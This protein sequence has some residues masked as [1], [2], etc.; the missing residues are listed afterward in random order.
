MSEMFLKRIRDAAQDHQARTGDA[1]P[2]PEARLAAQQAHYDAFRR[3]VVDTVEPAL[4]KVKTE[5]VKQGYD[6]R[7]VFTLRH[8]HW[9]AIN[10]N[11]VKFMFWKAKNDAALSIPSEIRIFR[12]PDVEEIEVL[13]SIRRP[14]QSAREESVATLKIEDLNEGKIMDIASQAIVDWL[15]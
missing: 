6:S 4:M 9:P 10:S 5:L 15:S 11:S 2:S 8:N 14:R 7:V 12:D 1:K 13:K 3:K